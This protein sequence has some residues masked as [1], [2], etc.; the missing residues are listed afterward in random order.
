MVNKDGS[1]KLKSI[2]KDGSVNKTTTDVINEN[3]AKFKSDDL[4]FS[5]KLKK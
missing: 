5:N 1:V 4:K 2:N 3:K